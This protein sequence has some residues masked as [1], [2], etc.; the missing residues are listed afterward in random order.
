VS[1]WR[2]MVGSGARGIVSSVA[3]PRRWQTQ[4]MAFSADNTDPETY[5]AW[6]AEQ[7]RRAE[8]AR[9]RSQPGGAE[10]SATRER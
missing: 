2:W 8:T 4:Y 5:R 7:G 10:G 3:P 6:V 9:T 1:Q